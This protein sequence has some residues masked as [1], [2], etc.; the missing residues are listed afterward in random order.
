MV[1]LHD[2]GDYFKGRLRLNEPLAPYTSLNVGGP[3]D[4]IV[5]PNSCEDVVRAITYFQKNALP[6]MLIARRN[7][8]LVSDEGYHGA[9]ITLDPG[10]T[11]IRTVKDLPGNSLVRVDAGVPLPRLVDFCIEKSLQGMEMFAGQWRTVG[12]ALIAEME[13]S[14]SALAERLEE[15]EVFR[16]G[17]TDRLPRD[18]GGIRLRRSGFHRDVLL[19]GTFRLSS[20]NKEQ[21]LRDRR[22]ALL[23]TSQHTPL[24][25]ANAGWIFKDPPGHRAAALIEKAGLKGRAHGG[26]MFSDRYMDFIV[27][28]A[29]AKAADVFSLIDLARHRVK[30]KFNIEL[31]LRLKLVGFSK[32][33][34][35]E[36]A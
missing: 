28:T 19:S 34:L 15:I 21:L 36:V 7:N 2:I 24:N 6:V 11:Q 13:T 17:R 31:E 27:T 14:G 30:L 29:G 25:L 10:L 22:A 16:D 32:Q 23:A 33:S 12:G 1:S 18:S 8:I 5:E 35:R 26:A 3:A 4:Y 9:V 20:G